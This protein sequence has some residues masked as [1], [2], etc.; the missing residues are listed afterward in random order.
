MRVFL[1]VVMALL[2]LA[3][4]GLEA[5]ASHNQRAAFPPRT[6]SESATSHWK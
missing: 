3:L 2:V 5:I 4:G 6:T 1:L